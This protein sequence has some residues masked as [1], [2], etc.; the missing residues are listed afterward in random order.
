MDTDEQIRNLYRRLSNPLKAKPT[1][2]PASI[3]PTEGIRAV[4][5]DVYGTLICSGVGDIS[6]AE[7]SGRDGLIRDMVGRLGRTVTSSSDVSVLFNGM[8]KL[9]HAQSRAKGIDFPE[10][11]IRHIWQSFF[12]KFVSEPISADELRMFATEFE[13]RVNPVWPYDDLVRVLSDLKQRGMPMGIVSNAQFYTP[14]MLEAFVES[15]LVTIGFDPRLLVWS[16]EHQHGKPS[17]H[18]FEEQARRLR[19]HHSLTPEQCL[20]VGNDMLKD[21]WAADQVGFK[22]VLFAGDQRS[23]RLREDDERCALKPEATIVELPQLLEL[24]H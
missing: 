16:F 6:L 5:F 17:L 10:I 19:E 7:A 14:L 21:I 4:I 2:T 8:I 15:D 24:I 12:D 13:C 23:L 11:D 18:L 1:V 9:D 3:H 22:T 20:Y